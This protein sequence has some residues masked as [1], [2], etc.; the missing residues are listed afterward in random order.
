MAPLEA[1]LF[2]NHDRLSASYL[3]PTPSPWHSCFF[4]QHSSFIILRGGG[5]ILLLY[6]DLK[7]QPASQARDVRTACILI[8]D[9]SNLGHAFLLLLGAPFKASEANGDRSA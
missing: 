8:L 1:C 5:S 9:Q 4:T 2:L 7:E 6:L 3:L